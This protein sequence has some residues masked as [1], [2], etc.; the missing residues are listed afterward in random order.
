M[1]GG[2]I[3]QLVIDTGARNWTCAGVGVGEERAQ[4]QNLHR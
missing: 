3:L 4:D 2:N 1:R